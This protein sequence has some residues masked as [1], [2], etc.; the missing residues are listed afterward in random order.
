MDDPL[1]IIFKHTQKN[2]LFLFVCVMKLKQTMLMI[3]LQ[4]ETRPL[5]CAPQPSLHH[6]SPRNFISIENS[7]YS[8]MNSSL[9][10]YPPP[11]LAPPSCFPDL[12]GTNIHP[13][14]QVRNG[15]SSWTGPCP[16]IPHPIT[17][18][19]TTLIPKSLSNLS[20]SP[21]LGYHQL[22]PKSLQKLPNCAPHFCPYCP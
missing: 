19:L 9:L 13:I 17:Q 14:A 2:L 16:A 3:D 1:S 12:N 6:I 20:F 7:S 11:K 18:V 5:S 15:E 21:I 8:K 4:I 10:P 22:L